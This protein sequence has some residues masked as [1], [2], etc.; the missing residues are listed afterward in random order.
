MG[1]RRCVSILSAA[2]DFRS[3]LPKSVE[4][5]GPASAPLTA[6]VLSVFAF[7]FACLNRLC[8][9]P[10]SLKTLD[11]KEPGAA[12]PAVR[13]CWATRGS[14][15]GVGCRLAACLTGEVLSQKLL[16]LKPII[17]NELAN[18]R[19]AARFFGQSSLCI[20]TWIAFLACGLIFRRCAA[21]GAGLNHLSQFGS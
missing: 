1:V 8:S 21:H 19:I 12:F 10:G 20:Q 9:T 6:S 17:L 16:C 2:G 14:R 7:V 11:S 15:K 13:G 18:R 5:S 3:R 4:T